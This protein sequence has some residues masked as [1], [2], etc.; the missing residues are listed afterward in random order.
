MNLG[1]AVRNGSHLDV[2]LASRARLA[3]DIDETTDASLAGQLIDRL[4][5]VQAAIFTAIDR[6]VQSTD[7]SEDQIAAARKAR[8]DRRSARRAAEGQVRGA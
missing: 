1:N 4:V 7:A 3:E 2:L 8:S 6:E 5:R